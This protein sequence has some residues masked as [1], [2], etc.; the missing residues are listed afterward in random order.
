LRPVE[1]LISAR[2]VVPVV[3]RGTVLPDHSVAIENGHIV[4][5]LPSAL[6]RSQLEPARHLQLGHH[7]LAPGLINTHTHAAMT[8]LRGAGDDLPLARW[9][10]ERIWP[11]ERALVS[12]RFVYDGTRHAAAEMLRAGITCCNDMYFFPD[13]AAHAFVD[14]GMRCVVGIIAVQFPSAYATDADDYLRKGLQTRDALREEPLVSFT[15]A[16][17]ASYTVDDPTLARI[18]MLAEELDLPV[19]THLHETDAEIGES[20]K[21][22]GARPLARLDRLGLVSERL[23]AVH[24]VHL[25]P[26]EIA[27]LA[28]RGAS[29]AHCPAS[30]LKLASG[31]APIAALLSQGVRVAF[32]T[33]G[34]ASNN[35]LD[36]FEEMRLA[37]L[38]AKGAALDASVLPAWQ[39]LE[40]ATITAAGALGLGERIGSIEVGKQADLIAVDLSELETQPCLDVVSQLVYCAG[41]EHVSSVWVA[42]AEVV[43]DR[44]LVRHGRDV[45]LGAIAAASASWQGQIQRHFATRQT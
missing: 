32:G 20:V 45:D 35:R 18:A 28:Q 30:N 26:D 33:D 2:W 39:A 10:T 12:E 29:V 14:L 1:T 23:L 16:P 24:A 34:A 31:I 7:A 9:L 25:Q 11:L 3:P 5:V 37:A 13:A 4:A 42:G 17:H 21:Q 27:L 43:S 44:R 8:L 41:R 36:L 6:A 22:H 19:H 40:C 15:L 38:L